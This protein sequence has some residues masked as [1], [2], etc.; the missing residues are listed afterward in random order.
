MQAKV[1]ISQR[2]AIPE[3]H[4]PEVAIMRL[5]NH[6]E[7]RLE[8]QNTSQD[9]IKPQESGIKSQRGEQRVESRVESRLDSEKD[10]QDPSSNFENFALEEIPTKM[11]IVD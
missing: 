9:Q 6:R 3:G 8:D 2:H 4:V 7:L 5:N 11:I 10:G 1:K